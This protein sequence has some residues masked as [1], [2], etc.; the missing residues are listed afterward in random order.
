[1]R[2]WSQ[3]LAAAVLAALAAGCGASTISQVTAPSPV[4]CQPGLNGLPASVASS[5]AR[6]TAT[7]STTRDCAWTITTDG[8]WIQIDPGSGQGETSISVVVAENRAT[9]S[10]SATI[11]VNDVPVNLSQEPAPPPPPPPAPNPAPSPG[12]TP[13]PPTGQSVNFNG[14]VSNLSG[15]CPSLSFVAD[16]RQVRTDSATRFAGGKCR[17]VH[18]GVDVGVTGELLNGIV[19]ATKIDIK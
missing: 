10:R 19:R 18:N 3:C 6:L 7:V 14:R 1:M 2:V 4:K 11:R 5:G 12:P 8:S 13:T 15:S 17:D 9:D 16:Q